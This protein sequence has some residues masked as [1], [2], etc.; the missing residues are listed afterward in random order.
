MKR[1]PIPELLDSD[2]GTS[3]EIAAS[4][5]DLRRINRWFGGIS[6]AVGL[7]EKVAAP[8][9][10]KELS[11]LDVAGASGDIAAAASKQLAQQGTSLV[12]T[13]LDKN[14]S[15]LNGHFR[16]VIGDALALPFRD[17]SFDVVACSTFLHHLEPPEIVRFA[18]EAQ[19]VARMAVLINDLR[20]HWLHLALVYAGL[21]LFHS[22]LTWH[23]A[24]ASVRRAYTP[25]ELRQMLQ[26][27]GA[28]RVEITKHYLFR[29]G[30]VVWPE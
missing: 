9:G 30:A 23:D 20:R 21:P 11:F 7:I 28:A 16:A 17:K 2:A 4:L 27:A 14:P 26:Q 1:T 13:V 8:T 12:V 6:T 18:R 29:M 24:P 25:P 19:R 10:R 22:R 15:H 3:A 5:A